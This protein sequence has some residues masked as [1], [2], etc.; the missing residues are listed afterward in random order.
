MK[1]NCSFARFVAWDG[2]VPLYECVNPASRSRNAIASDQTCAVCKNIVPISKA[3][4]RIIDTDEE[5]K[6]ITLKEYMDAT[7]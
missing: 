7:A 5:A 2:S 1:I 3:H 6:Q 4:P